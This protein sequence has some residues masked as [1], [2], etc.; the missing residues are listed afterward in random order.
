MPPPPHIRIEKYSA[1]RANTS[2]GCPLRFK[3]SRPTGSSNA[4]KGSESRASIIPCV[5]ARAHPRRSSLPHSWATNVLVI[6]VS[7]IN[8]QT[9]VKKRIPPGREARNASMPY[10]DRNSRSKKLR[11]AKL[12]ELIISGQ[13]ICMSSRRRSRF[14]RD[15]CIE[16][17]STLIPAVKKRQKWGK[18]VAPDLTTPKDCTTFYAYMGDSTLV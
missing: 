13:A 15:C 7:A 10:Q 11:R 12:P 17:E 4:I 5:V 14:D 2:G 9:S 6:P 16:H 8:P 3:R 18:S 1:S